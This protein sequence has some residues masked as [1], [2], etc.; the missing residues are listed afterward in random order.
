MAE[1]QRLSWPVQFGGL[2]EA[3]D[4][5]EI[6]PGNGGADLA[7]L[8]EEAKR[9]GKLPRF[10]QPP[11]SEAT[12]ATDSS[13]CF[14]DRLECDC[15]ALQVVD[16]SGQPLAVVPLHQL[17]WVGFV[18]HQ[19]QQEQATVV[20][21]GDE[22]ILALKV[23]DVVDGA[24]EL[25]DVLWLRAP[26]EPVAE[27]ICQH[28][29]HCFQFLYRE[30]IAAME[31]LQL[32]QHQQQEGGEDSGGDVRGRQQFD[33][34]AKK[35]APVTDTSAS[36]SLCSSPFSSPHRRMASRNSALAGEEEE[37]A[38]DGE[39]PLSSSNGRLPPATGANSTSTS[40]D[41]TRQAVELINEY[42]TML[43]ACLTHDELNKFAILMRRWR[44]REMPIL[45]FAQKLL[46]LY[47]PERRHL[48]A[49]MRSLLRGDPADLEA[50]SDFLRANGVVENAAAR[51][52]PLT[53]DMS[54]GSELATTASC[55]PSASS[56]SLQHPQP[57]SSSATLLRAPQH[58]CR[59]SSS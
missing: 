54:L 20:A 9:D 11:T 13:S 29:V 5:N 45:E 57:S 59:P 37:E 52:P 41:S 39:R 36:A 24:P 58:Q 22:N 44:A 56:A 50:L 55:P 43:S 46:E 21:A 33:S 1:P 31:Q 42:L 25:F 28:F 47:G 12:T 40:S 8:L 35:F 49:R 4:G 26:S 19:Q 38:E 10:D 16:A 7:K 27:Q 32:E 34:L 51:S 6:E 18:H 23:G 53:A 14:S 3:I 15:T 48:L 17:A 30:A 2:L